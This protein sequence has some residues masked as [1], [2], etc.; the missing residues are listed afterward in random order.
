[1]HSSQ[2]NVSE[3][4][5][6]WGIVSSKQ[7]SMEMIFAAEGNKDSEGRARKANLRVRWVEIRSDTEAI[8]TETKKMGRLLFYK[9]LIILRSMVYTKPKHQP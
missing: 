5:E 4:W 6:V 7:S 2:K 9:S 3:L 1:M 8:K